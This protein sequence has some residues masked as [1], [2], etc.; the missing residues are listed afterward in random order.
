MDMILMEPEG[1]AGGAPVDRHADQSEESDTAQLRE[2][3]LRQRTAVLGGEIR[4]IVGEL[5]QP[6]DAGTGRRK[7]LR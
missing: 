4:Q 5:I 2:P 3:E 1:H 7:G 6:I